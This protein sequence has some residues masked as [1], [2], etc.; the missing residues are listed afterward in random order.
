MSTVDGEYQRY[1][2]ETGAYIRENFFG[3]DP[4]CARWRLT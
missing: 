4:D 3:P 1:A 2:T